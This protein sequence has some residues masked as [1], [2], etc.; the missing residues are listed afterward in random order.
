VSL[1]STP[2]ARDKRLDRVRGRLL[3]LTHST[4]LI[5]CNSR[6]FLITWI[7]LPHYRI[8]TLRPHISGVS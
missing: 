2:I 7:F 1:Q 3:T 4:T 6:H 8:H 5:E